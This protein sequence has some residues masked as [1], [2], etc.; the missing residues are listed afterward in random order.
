MI[1]WQ[2]LYRKSLTV[3]FIVTTI[4]ALAQSKNVNLTI[5]EIALLDIE[6]NNNPIAFVFQ[7]P[8]EAGN[9]ITVSPDNSKWI[10]Y[11]A[12]IPTGG[13]AKFITVELD[14]TILGMDIKLVAGNAVGGSGTLGTPTGNLTLSTTPTVLIQGI[15]GS[16]TGNGSGK[17]HQLTFTLEPYGAGDLQANANHSVEVTYTIS[18]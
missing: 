5:P 1:Q 10:N 18:D 12:T 16:S 14:G 13:S 9:P 17:G 6:P 7:P 11:S 8:T 3:I 4:G 15:G 2:S